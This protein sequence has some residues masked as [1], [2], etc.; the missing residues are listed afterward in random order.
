[1]IRKKGTEFANSTTNEELTNIFSPDLLMNRFFNL[2]KKS[3]IFASLI[4]GLIL[5]FSCPIFSQV[6]VRNSKPTL[7]PITDYT[8]SFSADIRYIELS[9]ISAGDEIDQEVIIDV[10][11]E[12][13]DLIESIGADL[14]DNGKAYIHYRLKEGAAGTAT[15]KVVVTDNGATPSSVART[16]HITTETLNRELATKP[17]VEESSRSLKAIP[18][19]ALTSTRLFF[20]TPHDEQQLTVDLYSLSGAKIRQL[21]TGNTLANRSYYVDVNSK[22]LAAGVYLVRLTGQSH[23]A[24]LKLAV[25]K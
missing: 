6:N 7:D 4:S 20:S 9:G 15:V 17:L 23:T 8:T 16:F 22:N 24:N 14:V 19:P 13:E 21:F 12:D 2:T 25:A 18:N 5:C 10:S 11:T 1:M 3:G